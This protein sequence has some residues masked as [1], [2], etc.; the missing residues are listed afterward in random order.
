MGNRFNPGD[1]QD[2]HEM[3]AGLLDTLKT[4]ARKDRGKVY[5]RVWD[6]VVVRQYHESKCMRCNVLR[7]KVEHE[8][9][10][11]SL[12]FSRDLLDRRQS[13]PIQSML[14]GM[15]D[16]TMVPDHACDSSNCVDTR[17]QSIHYTRYRKLGDVVFVLIDRFVVQGSQRKKKG[18]TPY[19]GEVLLEERST[20]TTCTGATVEMELCGVLLHH[21]TSVAYGHCTAYAL[22]RGDQWWCFDDEKVKKVSFSKVRKTAKKLAYILVFRRRLRTELTDTE[23][24][25]PIT[26]PQPQ[27]RKASL[28]AGHL[29]FRTGIQKDSSLATLLAPVAAPLVSLVGQVSGVTI[30][31]PLMS[32]TAPDTWSVTGVS[33]LLWKLDLPNTPHKEGVHVVWRGLDGVFWASP[34]PVQMFSASSEGGK[35]EKQ[36]YYVHLQNDMKWDLNYDALHYLHYEEGCDPTPWVPG[37][38]GKKSKLAQAFRAANPEGYRVWRATFGGCN[39]SGTRDATKTLREVQNTMATSSG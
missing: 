32:D 4:E 16:P 17:G 9:G 30:D 33:W 37:I 35:G 12:K 24:Y 27:S 7:T 34:T 29:I 19:E 25:P 38:S 20:F 36:H 6:Q 13:N 22:D 39:E 26:L 15:E 1:Q 8:V 2:A 5:D 31:E 3:L 18:W 21:G 28:M 11:V 23:L 10:F 14:D